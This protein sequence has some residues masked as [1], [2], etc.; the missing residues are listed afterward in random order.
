M[1]APSTMHF[2]RCTDFAD[3]KRLRRCA[4]PSSPISPRIYREEIA[5]LAKAGCRYIQLDEVAV[6]MLCDPAIR[7]KVAAP[8][9]TPTR[10]SISTSRPST[11]ASP[12]APADMLIGIH[13]CR[14][15]FRGRYLSEG[16]YELVAERFF[17]ELQRHPLPARVRH[18]RAGDFKPL[19]FVPKD[20]GVVLGLVS[21]K[22]PVLERSKRLF[23]VAAAGRSRRGP[24]IWMPPLGVDRD[25]AGLPP[26][27]QT[28]APPPPTSLVVPATNTRLRKRKIDY[29]QIY[30]K[31]KKKPA[32]GK[33]RLSRSLLTNKETSRVAERSKTDCNKTI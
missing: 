8:A 31:K 28:T 19:R 16:G 14:G 33:D 18:G 13:M 9:R 24:S 10:W 20:K 25:P 17:A 3:P 27:K 7:D 2:Y 1:P 30:K 29:R 12:G 32:M 15:N 6:A 21:T 5:D 4:R 26:H 22:T 23:P 11:T